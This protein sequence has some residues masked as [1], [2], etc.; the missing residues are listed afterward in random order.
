ME[1]KVKELRS[2]IYS[3]ATGR[4]TVHD[5]DYYAGKFNELKCLI[6]TEMLK[7]SQAHKGHV[8][9]DEVPERLVEKLRDMGENGENCCKGLASG[10]YSIQVLY[11]RGILR[12]ALLRHIVALY[13]F[14]RVFEPFAFGLTDEVSR[15]F[16]VVDNNILAKGMNCFGDYLTK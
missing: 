1:A 4:A 2:Q 8:L 6:E 12:H 16:K 14:E 7:L 13:L 11:S 3:M 10:G 9:S 15:A 5:D